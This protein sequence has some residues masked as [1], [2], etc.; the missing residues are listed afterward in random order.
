MN[1]TVRII[2]RLDVKGPNV[3]KGIQFEGY[4]VL[5]TA[6]QFAEIYYQQGADELFYQDTVASLYQ[7]KIDLDIV[8][9]TAI[10]A[11]IPITV[12]GGVSTIDD[13]KQVLRA[14]ADKVAINT[15]ATSNP[16]LLREASRRFGSQCIVALIEV[17]RQNDGRLQ[18]WTDYGRQITKLDAR[19]WAIRVVEL[20][21]GEVV[22]S[23][24]NRDG[25]GRGY[26]LILIKELSA[27]LPVPVVACGGAGNVDDLVAVRLTGGVS[28]ICAAS[29]F[30]YHYAQQLKTD[31]K[32]NRYRLRYGAA[33]D[34]GNIDFLNQDCQRV[35]DLT[36]TP[37]SIDEVKLSLKKSGLN[38]RPK[39]WT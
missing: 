24:I 13:A 22:I 12:A 18:V 26:D 8:K 30:H 32:N 16:N 38:I 14:G 36:I 34:T 15:A 6:E 25:T 35:K 5:G 4:R 3:V 11:L 9:K 20:G 19:E 39:D 29:I 2:P 23:S 17:F 7:R 37:V 27:L 21:A 28:G 1:G 10:K 33:R 31:L